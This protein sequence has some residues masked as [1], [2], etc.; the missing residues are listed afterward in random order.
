MCEGEAYVLSLNGALLRILYY[1]QFLDK[2]C[3]I[4][5]DCWF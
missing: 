1:R 5:E 4:Q 3:G 2:R